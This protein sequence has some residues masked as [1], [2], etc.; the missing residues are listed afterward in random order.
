L[1]GQGA[2]GEHTPALAVG[3]L[4]EFAVGQVRRADRV[5]G[6]RGDLL[7]EVGEGTGEGAALVPARQGGLGPGGV[8]GNVDLPTPLGPGSTVSSPRLACAFSPRRTMR[9]P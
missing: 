1:L 9:S 6:N 5:N 2:G 8:R 7:V 3:Q 4:A